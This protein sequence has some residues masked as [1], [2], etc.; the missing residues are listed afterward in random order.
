MSTAYDSAQTDQLVLCLYSAI[1]LVIIEWLAL[2][3]LNYVFVLD[4]FLS[5]SHSLIDATNVK[6][7]FFLVPLVPE[8][9]FLIKTPKHCCKACSKYKS[10]LIHA[11][12]C[13][14]EW[15]LIKFRFTQVFLLMCKFTP[16]FTMYSLEQGNSLS[17]K[18][19]V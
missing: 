18:A 4:H 19:S 15:K 2:F 1:Y 3:V 13:K 8:D 16:I 9:V 6:C 12:W 11:N 17:Q 7:Q 10:A 14:Y 5:F